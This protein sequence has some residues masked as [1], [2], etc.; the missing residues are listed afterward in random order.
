MRQFR[1][2]LDSLG[3]LPY[4]NPIQRVRIRSKA[5]GML[6]VIINSDQEECLTLDAPAWTQARSPPELHLLATNQLLLSTL[7]RLQHPGP[8]GN[9]AMLPLSTKVEPQ[10]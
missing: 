3:E 6:S 2:N 9:Y 7:F 4:L 10:A 5:F 8:V 1:S